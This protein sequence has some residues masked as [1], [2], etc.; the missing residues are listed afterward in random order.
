MGV[1]MFQFWYSLCGVTYNIIHKY[2]DNK[3]KTAY[4]AYFRAQREA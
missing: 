2:L 1:V 4:R 3:R